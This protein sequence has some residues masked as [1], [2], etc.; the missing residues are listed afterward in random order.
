M[1]QAASGHILAGRTPCILASYVYMYVEPGLVQSL[2]QRCRALVATGNEGCAYFL[3]VVTGQVTVR[4]RRH[5][6]QASAMPT[7]ITAVVHT[8]TSLASYVTCH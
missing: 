3:S 2:K 4:C 7:A 5:A 8:G 1:T 6:D